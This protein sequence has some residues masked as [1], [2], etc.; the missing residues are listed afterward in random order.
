MEQDFEL[1]FSFEEYTYKVIVPEDKE[2]EF[3]Q[4]IKDLALNYTKE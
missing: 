3:L 4:A 1:P 2:E